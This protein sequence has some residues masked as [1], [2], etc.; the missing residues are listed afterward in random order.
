MPVTRSSGRSNTRRAPPAPEPKKAKRTW[1]RHDDTHLQ[2]LFDKFK[3]GHEGGF[4]PRDKSNQNISACHREQFP[5][6][7]LK[8]FGVNFRKKADE[9]ECNGRISGCGSCGRKKGKDLFRLSF[10]TII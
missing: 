3:N 10:I 7:T 8:K 1:K 5:W 9:Y 4:D 6:S 2:M